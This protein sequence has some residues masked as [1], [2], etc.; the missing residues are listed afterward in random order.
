MVKI[1]HKYAIAT[2]VV[3]FTCLMKG[4]LIVPKRLEARNKILYILGHTTIGPY[5]RPV[6]LYSSAIVLILMARILSFSL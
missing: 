3:G 1:Q 4:I 2:K 6:N 5:Y